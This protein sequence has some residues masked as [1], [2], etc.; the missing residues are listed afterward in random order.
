MIRTYALLTK[1][2]IIFGNLVTTASGFLLASK[3]G[4]DPVLFGQTL[5]GLGAVIASACVINN[6]I[7]RKSDQKMERTKDRPL[8]KGLV[9]GSSALLLSFVLALFGFS[10]LFYYTN[11]SATLAAFGGF[12]GYV[13]VYSML[14]H[15]SDFGTLAGSFAGALPPVTGYLAAGGSWDLGALVLFLIL[16]FWQMPHFYAIAI[17]KERDYSAAQ[18]PVLPIVRGFHTAKW[19][20]LLYIT[21]FSLT[22]PLLYFMGFA[23]WGYACVSLLL[24]IGWISLSIKGFGNINREIWGKRMFG[25]SLVV[26]LVLSSVMPFA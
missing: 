25:F 16:L 21:A 8:A 19:H 14:K 23:G 3:E 10:I 1:P 26:I 22:A 24:S 18:I 6:Y 11:T 17:W 20:I 5:A 12:F 7:D 15:H 13:A 4:F 9:S 2:G